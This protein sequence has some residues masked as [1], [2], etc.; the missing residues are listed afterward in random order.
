[1][2]TN[3]NLNNRPHVV[4]FAASTFAQPVIAYLHQH[5]LLAG[6]IFPAA[7]AHSHVTPEIQQLVQLCQ[8]VGIAWRFTQ[9]NEYS[10]LH[11]TLSAWRA[12]TGLI[13]TYPHLLPRALL[14]YFDSAPCCGLYNL[15]AAPLPSYRG[16]QPL[17]W[18]LRNRENLSAM[19]LHRATPIADGGNIIIHR[20]VPIHPLDTLPSLSQRMAYEAVASCEQWLEQL[21]KKSRP[22][23]G[24]AQIPSPSTLASQTYARRP[25]PADRTISFKT[26]TASEISALCRAGNASAY[27][28]LMTIKGLVV[29]LLQATPV[30]QPSYGTPAGTV[31][32]VGEPEGLRVCAK[33][34][35]LRLDIIASTDGIYTGQAF[36]E[37]FDLDA[38]TPLEPTNTLANTL[39]QQ[40]A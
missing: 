26:M 31:L 22:L 15:H 20:E 38:G 39:F 37:R 30:E 27:S 6:V 19:V 2:P 16:P 7:A 10:V 40:P 34:S 23:E 12:N 36:A 8:S 9:A 35:V 32:H 18:Q 14:E 1:M 13:A 3:A 29:N 24:T 4:V 17:Y 33:N 28:A 11:K 21:L 5:K 25:T